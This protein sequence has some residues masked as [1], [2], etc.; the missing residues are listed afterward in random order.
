MSKKGRHRKA[1]NRKVLVTVYE[2]LFDAYGKQNWWPADTPFEVMVGAI[3][4]QNT[5]WLN[6]EKAIGNL[7]QAKCLQAEKILEQK[8]HEIAELIRPSGYF[9][10]KTRRLRNFCQWYLDNGGFGKLVEID[11]MSL[12]QSLL[13]VN[14]IG[15]ETADDILL[16][17][18]QRP[19]FVVDVYTRRLFTKLNLISGTEDYETIRGYFESSLEPDHQ[20]FNEYHALIVRHAKEKC[21][22]E[23]N[24]V[25]RHCMVETPLGRE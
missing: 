18:F 9:N 25:C 2:R 8:D 7:K 14:G 12:R 6:V 24:E 1:I 4:T 23:G 19:V 13:E 3:L 5:A 22:G 10:I 17:A 21:P 20:L 15:P 16:Y 11:T